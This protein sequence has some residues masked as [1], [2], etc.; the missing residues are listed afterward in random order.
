[1]GASWNPTAR[2]MTFECGCVSAS[3]RVICPASTSSCTIEWSTVSCSSTPPTRRY[4]R[5]SP[6][7][8]T[9]HAGSSAI[10]PSAAPVTV[11][12]LPS[13][14]TPAP[15]PMSCTAS[16]SDWSISGV[17]TSVLP[18]CSASRVT[19][20]ALAKS[21][22]ACPPMPSA[23]AKTGAWAMKLSSL[24]S[25]R[26]PVSVSAAQERVISVPSGRETRWRAL[27]LPICVTWSACCLLGSLDRS[28][29]GGEDLDDR[30]VSEV[31][32]AARRDDE[33]FPRPHPPDAGR[34]AHD[35][36]VRRAQIGRDEA[37]P[38]EP[39][40]QVSARDDRLRRVDDDEL[41]LRPCQAGDPRRHRPT[42]D[43]HRSGED[44]LGTADDPESWPGGRQRVDRS[45]AC[46]GSI[47]RRNRDTV[48]RGGPLEA[49]RD[50][51]GRTR[52]V[53]R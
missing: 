39:E 32:A 30:T 4:T 15:G 29:G 9:I 43:E 22:A 45:P 48:V 2:V 36:A 52:S 7:L 38:L 5:E 40:L 10:A 11:V 21:P 14:V 18:P 37:G 17:P 27:P 42:T 47:G 16:R 19:T 51:V 8:K 20:A 25:R 53:G 6:M 1:M 26:R 35:G 3:S 41:G 31:D 33:G 50:L 12:P 49:R 13:S 24:T 46:G 34:A 23:T 44:P 28:S